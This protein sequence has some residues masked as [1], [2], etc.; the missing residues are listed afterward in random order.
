VNY[1]GTEV[2]FDAQD[3]IVSKTDLKGR[4]IYA[5]HTFLNIA[6]YTEAEMIGKPHNIIRHQNM[7]MAIFQRLWDTITQGNEI[8]AYVVNATKTGDHYWVLAHVTPSYHKGELSGYHSTRRIP[9]HNTIRDVIE[10]VYGELNN[11]EKGSLNKKDG[12]Q[13]STN[14]FQEILTDSGMDYDEYVSKLMRN[15]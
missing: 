3:L 10:P 2:Y 13:K 15:Y 5:N 11:L 8:F 12:I 7:P 6:G 1:A 4:I 14:R 9:D